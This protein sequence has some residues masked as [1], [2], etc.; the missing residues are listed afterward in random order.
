[1][2]E[3]TKDARRNHGR[4]NFA[5]RVKQHALRLTLQSSWC[6]WYDGSDDDDNDIDHDDKVPGPW[7]QQG[8]IILPSVN[9]GKRSF[10]LGLQKRKFT[11]IVFIDSVR[12]AQPT[13][14]IRY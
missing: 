12:T 14:L 4:T 8:L 2:A 7:R 10:N 9:L 6:W 1:M 3:E 13:L 5:L 11:S